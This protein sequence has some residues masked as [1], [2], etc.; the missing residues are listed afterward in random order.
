MHYYQLDHVKQSVHHL[1]R[2]HVVLIMIVIKF[3][4]AS[5]EATLEVDLLTVRCNRQPVLLIKTRFAKYNFY[6]KLI[7][8]IFYCNYFVLYFLNEKLQYHLEPKDGLIVTG[9]CE[10]KCEWTPIEMTEN[11]VR[12]SECCSKSYCNNFQNNVAR[13]L[14]YH[15]VISFFTF[16][17]ILL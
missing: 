17:I 10:D 2:Q 6:Y 16:I 15:N 8:F 7:N 9:S 14:A 12:G 11:Y 5:Q 13:K 3:Y 1:N 4:F